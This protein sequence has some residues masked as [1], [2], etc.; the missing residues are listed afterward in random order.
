MRYN[1][2]L[3]LNFVQNIHLHTNKLDDANWKFKSVVKDAKHDILCE[4]CTVV[5][6]SARFYERHRQR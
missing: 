3:Q 6:Y 1:T 2:N 5:F 4:C